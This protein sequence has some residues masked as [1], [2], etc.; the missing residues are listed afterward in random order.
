MTLL[1]RKGSRRRA[2]TLILALALG[3]PAPAAAGT[4][5]VNPVNVLLPPDRV[6]TELSLA[7]A[8][9]EPV[10]VRVSVSR[11]TQKDGRDRFEPTRDIVVSPPIIV[12]APGATQLIRIGTRTRI[13]GAAYRIVVEEVPAAARTAGINV[14]LRLDLPFYVLAQVPAKAQLSWA[15]RR[16]SNGALIVTARNAG[17]RHAQILGIAAEDSS[18]R[19]IA[20]SR[21]MGVVLPES[22]R[23]WD[24]GESD[25]LPSQLVIRTADGETRTGLDVDPN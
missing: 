3:A 12:V 1:F 14:A 16:D 10:T 7:N 17:A 15:A 22:E 11:W 4:F 20:A 24:L 13:A 21:A 8:G 9:G 25:A 6:A 2:A 23:S 18:G 5:A 19:R